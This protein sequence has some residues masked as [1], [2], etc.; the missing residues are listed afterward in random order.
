MSVG[1]ASVFTSLFSHV[2][3]ESSQK[4]IILS[5]LRALA[6]CLQETTQQKSDKKKKKYSEY[7]V[8]F[9]IIHMEWFYKFKTVEYHRY[10]TFTQKETNSFYLCSASCCCP[11]VKCTNPLSANPWPRFGLDATSSD[12]I[13]GRYNSFICTNPSS[14]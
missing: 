10:K 2:P 8:S 3:V 11:S 12:E 4:E 14:I 5:T 1:F 13:C 6:N 9:H 7:S